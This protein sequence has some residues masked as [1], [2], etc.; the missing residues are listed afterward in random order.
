MSESEQ[1]QQILRE[2]LANQR[3]EGGDVSQEAQDTA[4]LWAEGK[5]SA[6]EVIRIIKEK[7]GRRP[8]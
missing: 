1:R 8:E 7:Y 5:I 4:Q 3:L 6:D 2:A